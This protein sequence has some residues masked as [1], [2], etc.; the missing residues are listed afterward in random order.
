MNKNLMMR[1]S[2]DIE[3]FL[4]LKRF[5]SNQFERTPEKGYQGQKGTFI[6]IVI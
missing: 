6:C 5:D 1:C 4:I 2:E 3:S